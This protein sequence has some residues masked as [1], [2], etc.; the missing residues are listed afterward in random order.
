M[1]IIC[2]WLTD[3]LKSIVQIRDTASITIP[4][5]VEVITLGR[6]P[7]AFWLERYPA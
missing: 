7:C 5:T 4:L 2:V 1:F 6:Y 3:I